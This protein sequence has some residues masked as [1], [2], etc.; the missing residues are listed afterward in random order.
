MHGSSI[1]IHHHHFC[2]AASFDIVTCDWPCAFVRESEPTRTHANPR[3][4]TR[5]HANPRKPT[6]TTP[7]GATDAVFSGG[8]AASCSWRGVPPCFPF[9][10]SFLSSL[11]SFLR[12]PFRATCVSRRACCLLHVV[13]LIALVPDRDSP[14]DR[15]FSPPFVLT[16]RPRPTRRRFVGEA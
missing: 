4:P 8:R 15:S 10:V 12:A 16:S 11:S 3:E 2:C 1:S 9:L 14:N 6:R 5:T 13:A 7:I